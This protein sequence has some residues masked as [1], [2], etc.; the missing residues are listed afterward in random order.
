MRTPS[1]QLPKRFALLIVSAMTDPTSS[2]PIA[3]RAIRTASASDGPVVLL[4]PDTREIG[5]VALAAASVVIAHAASLGERVAAPWLSD[6][7]GA[8]TQTHALLLV[9]AHFAP[10]LIGLVIVSVLFAL[11]WVPRMHQRVLEPSLIA[12]WVTVMASAGVAWLAMRYGVWPPTWLTT[13]PE[14]ATQ[15][16]RFWAADQTVAVGAWLAMSCLL[17]PLLSELFLRH[18]LLWWLQGRG[19]PAWGAVACSAAVFGLAWFAA[20][21]QA[22][23]EAALRHGLVAGIGGLA[24]GTLAVRGARGRGLG[25]AVLAFG[26]WMATEAWMLLRG[27]TTG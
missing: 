15:L 12:A 23:P 5:G 8:A 21:V 17:V 24:L 18:A 27:L 6:S 19:L 3:A 20:G 25:L 16:G 4:P 7:A 26:A 11:R 9:A 2:P 10:W 1:R 22:A 13:S 14:T